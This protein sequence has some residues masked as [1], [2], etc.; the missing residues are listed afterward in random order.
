MHGFFE[1]FEWRDEMLSGIFSVLFDFIYLFARV[2]S[3]QNFPAPLS[4][5]REGN[6]IYI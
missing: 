4:P 3:G 5:K 6:F 1:N 2:S